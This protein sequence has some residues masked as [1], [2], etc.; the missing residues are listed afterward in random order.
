MGCEGADLL[1]SDLFDLPDSDAGGVGH[2]GH[3]AP[4]VEPAALPPS[5]V[6]A[7]VP[8]VGIIGP[9]QSDH[10]FVVVGGFL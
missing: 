6:H 3:D 2:G 8:G 9:E 5:H 7:I 1:L 10:V 4:G